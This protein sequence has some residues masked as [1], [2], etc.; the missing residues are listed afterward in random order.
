MGEL[1]RTELARPLHTEGLHLGAPPPSANTTVATPHGSPIPFGIPHA[2]HLLRIARRIPAPGT[3]FIRSI[4][5]HGIERLA[6][7]TD[8]AILSEIPAVN[9]IFT[10]RAIAAVYNTIATDTPLLSRSRVQ[11]IS[12]VQTWL[13]DRNLVLRG[14]TPK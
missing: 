6:S 3:G 2:S 8:P 13:P 5:T 9:G 7:G 14:D 1:Y 4:Y 10:A 11:Q 12:R